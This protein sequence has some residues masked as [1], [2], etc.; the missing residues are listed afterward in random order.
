MLRT[1]GDSLP[2]KGHLWPNVPME[3]S[4]PSQYLLVLIGLTTAQGHAI[5][6]LCEG[7]KVTLE[8]LSTQGARVDADEADQIIANA[9]RVT[10]DPALGL[11]VGQ[12]LNLGAH[13]VVGQTLMACSDPND[14]LETLVRYGALLTGSQAALSRFS[15]TSNDRAGLIL[16]V[17][18]GAQSVR[19]FHEV[20]FSAAQKT[21]S[22]LLQ[23]P[24][25][26]L[27]VAFPYDP[28]CDTTPFI[29]IFGEQ[30]GFNAEDAL[31]SCPGSLMRRRLPTSNETLRALYDAE[32]A[33]LL[34]DLSDTA[35]YSDRT[36]TAL[37]RLQGQYP[38][39]DQM[40]A[41]LNLSTRT[42]RRRL[43][44]EHTT[45]RVLLDRVRLKRAKQLLLKGTLSVDTIALS[46]GFTDT[47]N[48]RRA[49]IKWSGESP[50]QWRRRGTS[51]S[52]PSMD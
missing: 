49:F 1:Q 26:D 44:Q 47:S 31:F 35:G 46:L 48:F 8:T 19:F 13:A 3:A 11:A 50:V 22:D 36:L 27:Q 38:R 15:D 23:N 17:N 16:S 5:A 32:C 30:V 33:R 41:M 20:I 7:T 42:Y 12:Q 51:S 24:I 28:P 29:R 45:F 6:S 21:L 25:T 52:K 18:L 14:A 37:N 2:N 34:S 39:L 40:A 10:G 4:I 43:Q 9:L